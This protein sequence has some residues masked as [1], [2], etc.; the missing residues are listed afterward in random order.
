MSQNI[1]SIHLKITSLLFAI[2]FI[3]MFDSFFLEGKRASANTFEPNSGLIYVGSCSWVANGCIDTVGN[4]L[5]SIYYNVDDKNVYVF[6]RVITSE[7]NICS[8]PKVK[9]DGKSLLVADAQDSSIW[10]L[11]PG[12]IQSSG[13]FA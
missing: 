4:S 2:L 10:W 13:T 12:A 11:D 8:V 1:I 6:N 9:P 3:F 7:V 5:T